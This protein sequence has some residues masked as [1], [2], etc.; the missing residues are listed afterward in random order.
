MVQLQAFFQ[1]EEY[2]KILPF[3]VEKA[4]MLWSA[5]HGVFHSK[6]AIQQNDITYLETL[7]S[8]FETSLDDELQ[9]LHTYQVDQ[10]GAYSFDRLIGS[11]DTVFPEEQR[12][13]GLIPFQAL[14]D[15]RSA[16]RC[17]AFDLPTAC[18]FHAFRATDAML[19][20]YCDHFDAHPKGN[21]R[22]WGRYITAL[23]DVLKDVAAT[24]K[25]NERTVEL[26]DSIRETDR[27]PLVH[28]ETNLDSDGALQMF[29]L[30]QNAVSLM[31]TDI[32]NSP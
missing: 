31:V 26:L 19:R 27:N 28:P 22:D 2:Q 17:L 25:P 14:I 15:F 32:K 8:A 29:N 30:C 24:K 5:A 4:Q 12:K 20:A 16:G 7:L 21:G 1:N 23:R 3:S 10:V 18:G 11:A 6:E 13:K 9:R